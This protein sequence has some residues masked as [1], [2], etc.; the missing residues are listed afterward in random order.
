MDYLDSGGRLPA[1]SQLLAFI[2]VS[3]LL[4]VIV[5]NVTRRTKWRGR[6]V[7]E[8]AAQNVEDVAD[9]F[10]S[11]PLPVGKVEASKT[12]ILSFAEFLKRNLI[13]MPYI[14]ELRV[15]LVPV[16]MGREH[17]FLFRRYIDYRDK[18]WVSID[19]QGNVSVNISRND[20]LNYQENYS[21]DQLCDGMGKVFI[22]FFEMY[23]KGEE[24][25]IINRLNSLRINVFS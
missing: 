6:E 14:E 1:Y 12:Y 21:F 4:W 16:M 22:D 11:R 23:R 9:G 19:F 8:L 17:G 25:R 10:T 15:I 3:F 5:L 13:A 24:I 2:T 7:F 20:Y 18:T